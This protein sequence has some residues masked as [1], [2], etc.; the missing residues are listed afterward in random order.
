MPGCHGSRPRAR[1]SFVVTPYSA[2]ESGMLLPA[3]PDM[4]P[5][6]ER[7]GGACAIFLDHYR[8]RST[9]PRFPLSVLRCR[10]HR[11]GFT[12]YPPGHVPYGRQ[13]IAPL[14][15]DGRFIAPETGT[16][17]AVFSETLFGASLD[18]SHR[19]QWPRACR[20]GSDLWWGT[21]GRRIEVAVQVCGVSP[22]AETSVREAQAQA[23]RAPLLLLC[24]GARDIALRPGYGSRGKA[25]RSVLERIWTGASVLEGLLVSGH[26]ADRW[27]VPLL[28]DRA[29]R[30]LRALPFRSAGT[31]PP[32]P[33]T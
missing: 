9:G 25:V 1:R 7:T 3:M 30:R 32:R 12:L 6:A 8:D 21:Q 33:S 15:P 27:G 10:T 2:D 29:S 17:D 23:L 14:A 24:D 4:C 20:G 19:R 22:G 31:G 28:W 13:S 11:V 26:L 16:V 5:R 18:A